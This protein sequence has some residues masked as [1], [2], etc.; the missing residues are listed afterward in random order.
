MDEDLAA[1]LD[2]LRVGIDRFED[3]HADRD[4]LSRLV[5]R[6]EARLQPDQDDEGLVDAAQ[7]SAARFET[8]HPDLSRVLRRIVDTLS[9]SGI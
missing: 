7:Q 4:D 5:E 1:A 3:G 8:D 2:D 6:V 9:A